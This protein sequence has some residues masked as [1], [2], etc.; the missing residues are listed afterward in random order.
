LRSRILDVLQTE[1][2][3][4]RGQARK[5]QIGT[6]DRS[7]KIRTYNFPQNRVTD[8]RINLTVHSLDKVLNGQLGDII[9][10]LGECHRQLRIESLGS[11]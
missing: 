4:E 9:G 8:H 11:K 6:G 5:K 3:E 1:Q 7:E 2:E 10:A